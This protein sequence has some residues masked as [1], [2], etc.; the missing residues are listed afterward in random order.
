[1]FEINL[2]PFKLFLPQIELRT[3]A[4][5]AKPGEDLDIS[6]STSPNSFVGLLGVDQSVLVL[7]KGNDIEVSSVFDD[8]KSYSK[9]DK[10][11]HKWVSGYESMMYKDFDASEMFLITNAKKEFGEIS[12]LN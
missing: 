12:I 3:S 1:M 2:K 10:F 4:S 5:V 8:L 11:N 6:I 9:A 7:K